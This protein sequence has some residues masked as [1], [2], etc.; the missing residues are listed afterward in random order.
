MQA[1]DG[2]QKKTAIVSPEAPKEI[3]AAGTAQPPT[4]AA[5]GIAYTDLN[6]D[7]R[8]LLRALVESYSSDMPDEVGQGL[9]R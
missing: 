3:R 6:G 5:P 4:D 9:A 2:N 8:S 1:L 7:Q